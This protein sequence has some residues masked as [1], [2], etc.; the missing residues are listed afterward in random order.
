MAKKG[1]KAKRKASNKMA[2]ER[3]A[4]IE[5]E[6]CSCWSCWLL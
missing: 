3:A 6:K 5:V 1:K 4:T 2:A